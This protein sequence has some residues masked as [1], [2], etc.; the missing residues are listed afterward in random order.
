MECMAS[1]PVSQPGRTYEPQG[2]I[3]QDG[4]GLQGCC[5]GGTRI[6]VGNMVPA[7]CERN[8]GGSIADKSFPQAPVFTKAEAKACC[9][10]ERR[11]MGRAL[12]SATTPGSGGE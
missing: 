3:F 8:P 9:R 2:L 10:G 7:C 1:Q 5:G 6:K 12:Q 11:D 4:S